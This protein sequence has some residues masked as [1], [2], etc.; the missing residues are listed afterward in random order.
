MKTLQIPTDSHIYGVFQGYK[1]I[2]IYTYVCVYIYIHICMYIY[3][4]ICAYIYIY[5]F[6]YVYIYL[7]IDIY[8]YVYIYMCVRIYTYIY[9]S[10]HNNCTTVYSNDCN[11]GNKQSQKVARTRTNEQKIIDNKY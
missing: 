5:I 6:I 1:Y 2:Y 10:K 9:M 7:C 11:S 4:H 3:I 8:V